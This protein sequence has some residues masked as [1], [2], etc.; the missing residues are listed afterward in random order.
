MKKKNKMFKAMLKVFFVLN[1]IFGIGAFDNYYNIVATEVVE[2]TAETDEQRL[3]RLETGLNLLPDDSE[4]LNL[5]EH[6]YLVRYLNNVYN[7]S[8]ANVKNGITAIDKEKLDK[9]VSK[10]NELERNESDSDKEGRFVDTMAMVRDIKPKNI[11]RDDIVLVIS[12]SNEV[13]ANS[14]LAS[15]VFFLPETML[16]NQSVN[17]AK[18]LGESDVIAAAILKDIPTEVSEVVDNEYINGIRVIDFLPAYGQYTNSVGWGLNPEK[19]LKGTGGVSLGGFGGYLTYE[20]EEPIQNNPQNIGGMDFKVL[21]NAFVGNSEPANVYVSEDGI[22]WYNLAGASHYEDQTIWDYELTYTRDESG[23]N[24][25]DNQGQTG[26]LSQNGYHSQPYWPT[27]ENYGKWRE[28][29]I[30]PDEYTVTG[31]LIDGRNL[32]WGYPDGN[33]SSGVNAQTPQLYRGVG[34]MDISWAVDE[35]GNPVYLK[36]IKYVKVQNATNLI[37]PPFGELSAEINGISRTDL[38]ENQSADIKQT[39]LAKSIKINDQ[40]F[41]FEESEIENNVIVKTVYYTDEN[42]EVNVSVTAPDSDDE[43]YSV[44]IGEPQ[45]TNRTFEKVP[46]KEKLRIV[47]ANKTNEGLIY[48][49]NF[50]KIEKPAYTIN[51]EKEEY[52]LVVNQEEDTKLFFSIEK[53][54]NAIVNY[55]S[56]DNNIATVDETGKIKA[57]SV[58]KVVITAQ[59]DGT[60]IKAT[61]IVNVGSLATGIEVIDFKD[62]VK[63]G[64]NF[65]V[66]TAVIP[67]DAINQEV[68][69]SSG[70]SA[71]AIIEGNEIIPLKPGKVDIIFE[72]STGIT[73]IKELTI[74]EREKYNVVVTVEKFTLGQGY[75]IEPIVVEITEGDTAAVIIDKVIKNGN[76]SY[77]NS[78]QVDDYTF[79]ISTINNVDSGVINI[80][81]EIKTMTGFENAYTGINKNT[82]NLGEFSYATTAGWMYFTNNEMSNVGMG[83]YEAKKDDVLR[84]QFSLYGYGADLGGESFGEM[85]SLELANKDDLIAII[86][87]INQD[88]ESC[89]EKTSCKT[90]YEDALDVLENHMSSQTV[91]NQAITNINVFNPLLADEDRAKLVKDLIDNIPNEVTEAD[92]GL[93]NNAK[94]AY[95]SLTTHQKALLDNGIITKLKQALDTLNK[96]ENL[97]SSKED[98]KT[99]NNDKIQTTPGEINTPNTGTTELAI[100][101]NLIVI[102]L[103]LS[104]Y[105]LKIRYDW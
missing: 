63:V 28:D 67:I 86:A 103:I 74:L 25:S 42:E 84:L 22:K 81:E 80:P 51:F 49:F 13:S 88:K 97:P 69:I 7:L 33:S 9:A 34:E 39:P 41:V 35:K 30:I 24:W 79:Y 37:V 83:S 70:N 78:G 52:S 98:N 92:K 61:T 95:D 55:S 77:V 32:A 11:T 36:E 17:Y 16:L 12:F 85:E 21:G 59:V 45:G 71:L 1:F 43:T 64:D 91:V 23:A 54:E 75:V 56:S 65:K 20:F 89:L 27:S 72:T 26:V 105:C 66:K 102:T 47:T 101:Y 46:N 73:E 62:S 19:T 58:G 8:K 60:D 31:T 48:L 93:I 14:E 100:A 44:F 4:K 15:S 50:E 82:P 76:I 87:Y 29:G 40:V 2:V 90:V 94:E 6:R 68:K 57:H 99:K 10:I 3:E 5:L 104:G 96:I 53:P 38:V 18:A